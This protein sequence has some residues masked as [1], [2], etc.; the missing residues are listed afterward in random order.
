MHIIIP[1]K[2]VPDTK[3]IKMDPEKGT[4]VRQENNSILNPLDMYAVET[5]LQFQEKYNN[6]ITTAISMGPKGAS[7]SLREALSMGVDKAVLLSDPSFAGS[8][9]W[10]TSFILS[11]AI[12]K[13]NEFD[14]IICG[15][16]AIDGDTGQV[17]PEIAS[18][19]DIPVLSYVNDIKLYSESSFY[20][21]RYNDF[22][23]EKLY[24]PVPC[25]IT[26]V[27]EINVPRL[28]TYRGKKKA[29][30]TQVICWNSKDLSLNTSKIGL[31]G[32]PTKV[33]KTFKPKLSRD[34]KKFFSEDEEQLDNA[35]QKFF[36]LLH[37]KN[38][39]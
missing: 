29:K 22:G 12:K 9:T 1:I 37:S 16:R 13:L 30:N 38:L 21:S 32:S 31:N 28:P 11:E 18:Y 4:I 6:V 25:L 14:L 33:V 39:I 23:I 34:C 17:G 20:L 8:D 2:Q 15:E 3:S 27:K 5:A 36:N 26:V 24:S 10:A 35:A 7:T 19:L